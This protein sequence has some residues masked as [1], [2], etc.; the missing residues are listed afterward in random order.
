MTSPTI[1]Q[2][3]HR[4]RRDWVSSSLEFWDSHRVKRHSVPFYTA[5]SAELLFV[6]TPLFSLK[7]RI[8]S[9]PSKLEVLGFILALSS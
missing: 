3:R 8:K 7:A 4:W 2:V 9:E 1:A 5:R 6:A